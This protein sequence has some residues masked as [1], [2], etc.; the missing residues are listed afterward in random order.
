MTSITLPPDLQGSLEEEARRLG[1][2]AE[3]LALEGLRR[4][5]GTKPIADQPL[6]G[7][8]LFEFL[9]GQIGR[10]NGTTEALSE[11]CG[12]RF[13]EGLAENRRQRRL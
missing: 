3:L 7:Q 2:T 6:P 1:T 8:T 4:L 10:V 12:Q 9:S 13:A 11:N 5:F